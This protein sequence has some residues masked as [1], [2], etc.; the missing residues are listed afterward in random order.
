VPDAGHFLPMEKPEYVA[1]EAVK[2]LSAK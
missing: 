2:F 1:D